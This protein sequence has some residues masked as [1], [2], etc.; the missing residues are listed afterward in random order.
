MSRHEGQ[1]SLWSRGVYRPGVTYP[2]LIVHDLHKGAGLRAVETEQ[3]G[4]DAQ[5][6][7]FV[8]SLLGDGCFF[9]QMN[10]ALLAFFLVQAFDQVYPT[11]W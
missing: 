7:A 6:V 5:E 4:P 8:R 2:E 10:F 1:G 3:A 11:F 9:T